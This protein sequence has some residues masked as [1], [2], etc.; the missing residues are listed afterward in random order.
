MLKRTFKTQYIVDIR[1]ETFIAAIEI[2][3]NF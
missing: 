1:M 2:C 3:K